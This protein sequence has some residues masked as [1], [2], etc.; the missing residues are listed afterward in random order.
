[1][2]TDSELDD[3]LA[4]FDRLGREMTATNHLLRAVQSSQ[5]T[6]NQ[7]EQAL[8]AEMQ[9][10]LRQATAA[11]QKALQASQTEIR[12]SILWMGLTAFLIVL[13]ASGGGYIF[14]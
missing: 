11:S 5:S 6:R 3:G 2:S 1:M 14:G 4:A 12:S 13:V 9:A 10:A 8:S 7:Q